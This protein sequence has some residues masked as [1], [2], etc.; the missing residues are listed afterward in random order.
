M[1]EE[2]TVV[3]VGETSAVIEIKA[4]EECHK[5][6][7][8]RVARARRIT[9]SGED[10]KGLIVGERVEI[11]L[12]SSV[13]LKLYFLI[14]GMPLAAFAGTA[15]LLHAATESPVLSFTGAI[16]ATVI[17][18]I[19]AGTYTKKSPDFTPKIHRGRFSSS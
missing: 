3:E 10:A 5:C 17:A 12:E 7:L 4:H 1:K 18:Y 19:A 16:L 6:G 2:G 8:C 13:M 15:L 11:E 14:Y 9:V